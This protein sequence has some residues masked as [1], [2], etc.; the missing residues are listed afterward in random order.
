[1][2][3]KQEG[4]LSLVTHKR[5]NL[6]TTDN[7][8]FN[9]TN[10]FYSWSLVDKGTIFL[11]ADFDCYIMSLKLQDSLTLWYSNSCYKKHY[12]PYTYQILK[13]LNC[14]DYVK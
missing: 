14:F 10:N 5:S 12:A 13:Y 4:K 6:Y 11:L 2:N 8:R 7:N 1:M 3:W 9:K